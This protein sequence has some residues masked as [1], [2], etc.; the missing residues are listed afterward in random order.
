MDRSQSL[1]INFNSDSEY[2]DYGRLFIE[3]KVANFNGTLERIFTKRK[4]L[5]IL[6]GENFVSPSS[7]LAHQD[8]ATI[9]IVLG[10][11]LC[12]EQYQFWRHTTKTT[13][14]TMSMMNCQCCGW[15]ITTCDTCVVGRCISKYCIKAHKYK[16][17]KLTKQS[18]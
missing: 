8:L 11:P 4:A 3:K 9:P 10:R 2:S 14:S 16:F 17:E 1:M 5:D 12:W 6:T 15:I 18:G 13:V 7:S